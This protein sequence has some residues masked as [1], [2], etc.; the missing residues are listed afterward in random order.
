MELKKFRQ[1]I[2]RLDKEL[3][4]LLN[5]RAEIVKKI[6]EIK[7]K[8]KKAFYS[9]EREKRIISHL[10]KINPGPLDKEAIKGIFLEVLH[11]CRALEKK[12]QIVYLGPEATFTHLAAIK[13]FGKVAEYLPAKSISDV[14]EDVRKGRADY[15]V[16][17]IEN[18]T[19]GIVNHTLDMFI[20]SDL[21]ICAETKLGIEH[22]LLSRE[23]NLKKIKRVYSH[24][25]ALAQCRNWLESHLPLA[26]LI[27]TAST[28]EAAQKAKEDNFS[29]AIASRL[30]SELYGLGIVGEKIENQLEN[31]TRFLIIGKEFPPPSGE[32][33]TS[34]MFSIKDRV[35]ALHDMLVP[36][37]KHEINL[38]KIESRPSRKKAWEYIFFVDFFGHIE[39]PEVK[40]ALQELERRC[41]FLKVL[42]S[43]PRGE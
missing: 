23:R 5:K 39:Q 8:K 25:Q 4:K 27:E 40:K 43:Y 16:V 19:E 28:A 32:D 3:L 26:R 37:K 14:F 30:A 1:E 18:S 6:G 29:A 35:G 24:S 34:I 22:Y 38:T 10:V 21:K 33:K 15:G 13:T 17:P 41:I 11:A 7:A 20:E 36:F 42:G 9:P 2:D 12:P 31:Y